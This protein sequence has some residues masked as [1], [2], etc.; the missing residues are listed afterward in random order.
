MIV[1]Q[2][3]T[4]YLCSNPDC[5]WHIVCSYIHTYVCT[6]YDFQSLMIHSCLLHCVYFIPPLF[7]SC[8]RMVE[9]K[10]PYGFLVV[11]K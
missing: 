8:D 5:T 1:G 7:L 11:M 2:T 6:V 4:C 3:I 10:T 9:T